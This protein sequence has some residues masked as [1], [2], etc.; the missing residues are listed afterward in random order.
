MG[1]HADPLVVRS[2]VE[3][4]A[5]SRGVP[6]PETLAIGFRLNVGLPEQLARYV[7]PAFDPNELFDL[8]AS[9]NTPWIF[10][11]VCAAASLVA[12]ALP[13][14]WTVQT[15]RYMMTAALS[16]LPNHRVGEFSPFISVERSVITA[17]LR[18]L[19]G[20]VVANGRGALIGAC[21]VFDQIATKENHR[22]RGLGRAIMCML[23]QAAIEHGCYRG[24]LV[25]TSDGFALYTAIGW[26]FHSDVTSAVILK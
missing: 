8:A 13:K 6:P 17:E 24:V 25:A 2:W 4:W 19:D 23:T 9:I 1:T 14:V 7:L 5:I 15:P 16:D 22:R 12:D 20:T 3:G 26:N 18:H 21:C 11:K 10:I